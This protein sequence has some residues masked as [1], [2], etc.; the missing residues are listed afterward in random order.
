[1]IVLQVDV[2][3]MLNVDDGGVSVPVCVCRRRCRCCFCVM[4][5]HVFV[6]CGEK[7]F[8]IFML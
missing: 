6:N 2:C 1:M 3:V 4:W 8:S 5:W 7:I